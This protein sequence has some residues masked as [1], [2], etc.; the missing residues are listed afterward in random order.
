[1]NEAVYPRFTTDGLTDPQ[2]VSQT[3]FEPGP[4]FKEIYTGI[5]DVEDAEACR[6]FLENDRRSL[7]SWTTDIQTLDQFRVIHKTRQICGTVFHHKAYLATIE[8]L[9]VQSI[10]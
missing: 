7:F 6:P 5:I 8:S 9:S 10:D 3:G 2:T 4:L 1:M